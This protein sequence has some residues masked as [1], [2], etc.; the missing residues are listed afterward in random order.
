MKINDE[1]QGRGIAAFSTDS[2]KMLHDLKLK[3]LNATEPL[4]PQEEKEVKEKMKEIC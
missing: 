1:V 4:P 2:I 3:K